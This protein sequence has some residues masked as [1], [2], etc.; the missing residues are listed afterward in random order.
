MV[1]DR[2]L[3][4]ESAG[5]DARVSAFVVEAGELGGAVGVD[6]AFGPTV[7]RRAQHTRYTAA[8]W[9]AA[10]CLAL[11]IR[12][13]CRRATRIHGDRRWSWFCKKPKW[14][15]LASRTKL[16]LYYHRDLTIEGPLQDMSVQPEK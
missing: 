14:I 8:N 13:A 10:D 1:D 4:V 2:A 12:S 15:K 3:R 5:S 6:Q 16:K 7:R 11:R 9:A